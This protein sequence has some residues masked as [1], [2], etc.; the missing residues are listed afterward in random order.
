MTLLAHMLV[1]MLLCPGM[2]NAQ[3]TSHVQDSPVIQADNFQEQATQ[4]ID[5]GKMDAALDL[6]VKAIQL[7]PSAQR[8]MNYGSMLFGNGVAVFKGGNQTKGRKILEEA[9]DQLHK[10]IARFNPYKDQVYLSQCFFL[11]GEMYT[12]FKA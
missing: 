9:E 3:S 4:D 6:M 5:D 1:L 8:Y 12:L 11:L 2:A 7:D 10:A